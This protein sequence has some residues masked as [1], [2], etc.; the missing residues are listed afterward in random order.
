MW[1]VNLRLLDQKT[2][3]RI[4]KRFLQNGSRLKPLKSFDIPT[5][6]YPQKPGFR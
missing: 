1:G 6:F 2:T 4:F 3:G 5:I